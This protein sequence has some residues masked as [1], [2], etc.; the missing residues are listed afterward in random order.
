MHATPYER[1]AA[2]CWFDFANSL[3]SKTHPKLPALRPRCNLS[4]NYWSCSN[5]R[6]ANKQETSS[7]HQAS[8]PIDNAGETESRFADRNTWLPR[9]FWRLSKPERWKKRCRTLSPVWQVLRCLGPWH[10]QEKNGPG[11]ELSY[12]RTRSKQCWADPLRS[13]FL[14]KKG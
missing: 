2:T 10:H 6:H 4:L 1:T 13:D 11:S 9:S 3:V 8:E 14:P 5:L 12:P 7:N